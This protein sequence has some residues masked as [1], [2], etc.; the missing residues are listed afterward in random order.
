VL[1]RLAYLALSSLFTV[2]RL[3]PVS[4]TDKDIEI[5]A[6]RHQLT[7]LHRQVERP[8]LS[9]TDR[10]FLAALLHRLPRVRLGQLQLIVS[11]ET[12]M[13]WHRHLVRRRHARISRT[14][15]PGRPPTRR[16]IQA[17]VLRLALV[18]LSCTDDH[19]CDLGGCVEDGVVDAAADRF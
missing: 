4:G 17:L 13:R 3:L 14:K 7:V 10:M 9:S 6:L 2:I 15:R 11:P 1:L 8:R 16:S 5:L 18:I 12:I 19:G